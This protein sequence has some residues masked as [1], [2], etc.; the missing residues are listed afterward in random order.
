MRDIPSMKVRRPELSLSYP[1][2]ACRLPSSSGPSS[3]QNLRLRSPNDPTYAHSNEYQ[4]ALD[5]HPL[6]AV[7]MRSSRAVCY[8]PSVC[9]CPRES[10]ILRPVPERVSISVLPTVPPSGVPDLVT[11]PTSHAR[12]QQS[13]PEHTNTYRMCKEPPL[14]SPRNPT[15]ESSRIFNVVISGLTGNSQDGTH[16]PRFSA[17]LTLHHAFANRSRT[18]PPPYPSS[19]N[20][21]V[22]ALS[23]LRSVPTYVRKRLYALC[24][25]D[26]GSDVL[27]CERVR[28]ECGDVAMRGCG[29]YGIGRT[30]KW[31]VHGTSYHQPLVIATPSWLCTHSGTSLCPHATSSRFRRSAVRSPLSQPQPQPHSIEAN[32]SVSVCNLHVQSTRVNVLRIYCCT[33]PY[34]ASESGTTPIPVP[35]RPESENFRVPY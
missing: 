24:T 3:T 5:G 11:K 16:D 25:S 6:C 7:C 33:A 35:P 14:R 4:S 17:K 8:H 28:G 13:E 19:S 32:T 34:H 29:D 26:G 20:I 10:A 9:L 31:R 15:V 2:H 23:P 1:S 30:S 21:R 27:P 12:L 22:K 18:L